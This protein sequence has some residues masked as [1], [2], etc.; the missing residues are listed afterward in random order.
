MHNGSGQ[1]RLNS[2]GSCST[3]RPVSCTCDGN[4]VQLQEQPVQVLTA[5][6]DRPGEIITRED[7]RER[8][9]K[10]DT[11]VDFDRRAEHRREEDPAGAR[12]FRRNPDFR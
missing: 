2:P 7:L 6:L 4:R 8:L 10:S 9:W 1:A 11:F 5:L 12:R 3:A